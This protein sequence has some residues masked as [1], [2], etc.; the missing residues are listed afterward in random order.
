[1]SIEYESHSIKSPQ[2]PFD[3]EILEPASLHRLVD[4]AT[5]TSSGKEHFLKVMDSRNLKIPEDDIDD[6]L[7]ICKSKK[8]GKISRE[9]SGPFCILTTEC[10][11][12]YR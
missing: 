6:G 5:A 10:P 2:G 9:I 8:R 3:P 4:M 12:I 11:E 1:M 7:C